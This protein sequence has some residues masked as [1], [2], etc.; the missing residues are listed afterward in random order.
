M[1][2][3]DAGIVGNRRAGRAATGAGRRTR[4]V[5]PGADNSVKKVQIRSNSFQ[6]SNG[7]CGGVSISPPSPTGEKTILFA[8]TMLHEF[9][10]LPSGISNRTAILSG[11][12][13][14]L[15]GEQ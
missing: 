1:G 10:A 2:N 7:T 6:C 11:T 4:A 12:L 15:T 8:G 13:N 14:T 5:T 9:T 3:R